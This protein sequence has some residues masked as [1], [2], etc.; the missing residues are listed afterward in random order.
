LDLIDGGEKQTLDPW[1]DSSYSHCRN[2]TIPQT[3][4][5]ITNYR[6]TLFINTTN[7]NYSEAESDGRDIRIANNYCNNS[8]SQTNGMYIANWNTTG[9]SVVR[10]LANTSGSGSTTYSIY[11]GKPTAITASDINSVYNSSTTQAVFEMDDNAN[12]GVV[13]NAMY[14]EDM[15]MRDTTKTQ[16]I[17]QITKQNRGLST[18]S[19]YG[20]YSDTGASMGDRIE[21]ALIGGLE[22]TSIWINNMTYPGYYSRLMFLQDDGELNINV[23]TGEFD[24]WIA[25]DGFAFSPGANL[26]GYNNFILVYNKTGNFMKF[27]INGVLKATDSSITGTFSGTRVEIGNNHNLDWPTWG[28]FD[29]IEFS[30]SSFF[31]S[32]W[33][34]ESYYSG[35]NLAGIALSNQVDI[36]VPLVAEWSNPQNNTPATYSNSTRTEFNISWSAGSVSKVFIESNFTGSATNYSMTSVY[37]SDIFNYSEILPAGKF[38]WKSYANDSDND[39]NISDAW[40]GTI[41]KAD[42]AGYMN[43]SLNGTEAGKV[44]TYPYSTANFTGTGGIAGLTYNLYVNNTLKSNPDVELLASLGTYNISYNTTGNTNWSAGQKTYNAT[45]T[46]ESFLIKCN[47]TYSNVSWGFIARDQDTGGN[48][49]H[50]ISAY[51]NY[52][53]NDSNG[54]NYFNISLVNTTNIEHDLCIWVSPYLNT[55]IRITNSTIQYKNSS[56]EDGW[57]WL[58]DVDAN[59]TA[60]YLYMDMISVGLSQLVQIQVNNKFGLGENSVLLQFFKFDAG[61]NSYTQKAQVMTDYSGRAY[62]YLQNN[63]WYRTILSQDSVPLKT[64]D[65]FYLVNQQT[66]TFTTGTWDIPAYWNYW[67]KVASQ[68]S[69]NN[70]TG[71]LVCSV[72]DT[73]GHMQSVDLNVISM[74]AMVNSSICSQSASGSSAILTCTNMTENNT[75]AYDLTGHFSSDPSTAILASGMINWGAVSGYGMYGLILAFMIIGVLGLLGSFNP[76]GVMLFTTLGVV[77]SYVLGLITTSGSFV[78]SL[79]GLCVACGIIIWMMRS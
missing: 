11:Y 9:T 66:L 27:Y 44:Y 50:N 68:C 17:T 69:F 13:K 2:I 76:A 78:A 22:T 31:N 12:S 75:Y 48:I 45:L 1:F 23:N 57:Y 29:Y 52:S 20:M 63:T 67:D 14:N 73:S 39:W 10:F 55:T 42:P 71:T 28:T 18:K 47:A 58:S 56:Y 54:I 5:S 59:Y 65:P 21:D 62:V 19:N 74:G 35:A 16:D 26:S 4:V 6:E 79:F 25:K 7:F 77:I 64:Y 40:Y 38:Y 8:G 34:N 37:G 30:N 15:A 61:N 70:N 3:N 46:I 53:T 32:D 43:L 36:N 51:F 72:V 33:I 49:S 24:V 41:G 60:Q